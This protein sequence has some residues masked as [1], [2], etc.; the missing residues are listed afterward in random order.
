MNDHDMMTEEPRMSWGRWGRPS[1]DRLADP[2]P[3][4]NEEDDGYFVD[5]AEALFSEADHIASCP[6]CARGRRLQREA[7]DRLLAAVNRPEEPEEEPTVVLSV[8]G[9]NGLA[10]DLRITGDLSDTAE[11]IAQA[12]EHLITR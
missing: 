3:F 5:T 2:A 10:M 8:S 7:T 9:P 11:L 12:L 4:P 1:V 6:I